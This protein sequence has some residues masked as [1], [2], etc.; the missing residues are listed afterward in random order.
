MR[1]ADLPAAMPARRHGGRGF[2][3]ALLGLLLGFGLLGPLLVTAGPAQQDLAAALT[4]PGAAYW[5]GTDHLGRSM[6][7]RLAHATRLSLAVAG[8]TVAVA[9][10]GGSLLG[11]L[12][13]WR[14]GWLDRLLGM[15][16][17]MV[18]A[19]PGLLLVLLVVAF[20]PGQVLPLALGIALAQWVEYF[21][22]ARAQGR[23]LLARP[24]VEA[25][26]LLGFGPGHVLRRLVL[27]E[28]APLLGTL[29]AFG[30]GNAVL[31]IATLSFVSVGIRPPTA[32]LGSMTT[33]LLPY[34][35]EAPFQALLPAVVVVLIV[36]GSLLLAGR[37]AR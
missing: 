27:P 12:A 1:T 8:L 2:G 23:S 22:V 35:A 15:A 21:R 9:S 7:A 6:L 30:L 11:L 10:V 34:M 37:G 4:P 26:R 3:L 19:L 16:A 36:L 25:A 29:A 32:E 28:L 18:L 17:D 5:L 20:A 24:Q 31:I 13:A 14:G 33:E